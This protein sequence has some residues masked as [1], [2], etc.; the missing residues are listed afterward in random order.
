L[1][2][3]TSGLRDGNGASADKLYERNPGTT[4]PSKNGQQYD[5]AAFSAL[6]LFF[7]GIGFSKVDAIK[8]PNQKT[9]VFF[10]PPWSIA[11]GLRASPLTFYYPLVQAMP[12]FKL[13]LNTKVIR[14]VRAGRTITGV[15][16]ETP[17][18]ARQIINL[19]TNGKVI[20]A[21]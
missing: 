7:F 16:V 15:E 1:T 19:N 20:L 5:Q 8:D 13:S 21:S 4:L 3:T 10:Y 12:N 11:N 17:T 18:G 6:S 9:K 2:S 14:A